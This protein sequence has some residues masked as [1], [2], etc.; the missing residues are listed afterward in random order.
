MYDPLKAKAR[1]V[2]YAATAALVGIGI[3][4]GLGWTSTSHAMPL[5]NEV[6]QVSEAAVRPALDL[7]DA[8]TNLADAVTPAVV[9]IES[10]RTAQARDREEVP[11]QFR[12]FFDTPEGTPAP[13]Q[14]QISGGSGFIVSSDGYILTNN[15]VV[16]GATDVR[17][18]FPDR[19]Y[20]QARIIG[21][22]PFTDVAVIKVDVDETLP[23]MVIG[24][25]DR[26]KVGEWILAIGNPGF[27][28][29]TQLDFTVTA[30]IISARGRGLQLLQRDLFNDPRYGADL[31]P[32]AIEDFIQTDAVINPGNSG[33]PMVNLRGQVVGIN[34]AIASTT[35]VYQG[36]GFAIPIN[37]ARRIMEDL[38][39]YGH[40]RRPRIG[41]TIE[42]IEAEDAEQYGL[43]S[44]SG[45]L[46]QAVD[47]SGPSAGALRPEDVIVRLD[48]E[49]VGYV[50]ELQA[51]IAE[52][53]PGDR[54]RLTVYRARQSIQVEVRLGDAPINDVPA[55]VAEAA[56]N[57]EERL[58]I[59]VEALDAQRAQDLGFSDPSGVILSEVARGSAAERRNINNYRGYKLIRIN[60]AEIAT[61]DDVRAAL[62]GAAAGEIVSLHFLH[63]NGDERVVNVRMP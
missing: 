26:I 13:P 48:D 45:V 47:R 9:R 22:D 51:E 7:S 38:V 39:E 19:R 5:L 28:A 63:P 56:T 2:M 3:A 24:D 62:V 18:Y 50:S 27:G 37:L 10:R 35:G 44:V 34:S 6:G 42:E 41:V 52:R 30:G 58:G 20:F 25:S 46:V 21:T 49:P 43:P 15:H 14:S 29:S 59:N 40:V 8:F 11:Q 54:V 4:A 16:E 31:S 1:V 33:G 32:Y 55:V 36:Y 60:D 17:V 61:P 57:A 12:Q 53:R 23:A